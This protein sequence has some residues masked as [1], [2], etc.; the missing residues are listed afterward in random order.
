MKK[1]IIALLLGVTMVSVG[2]EKVLLRLNY[3]KGDTY[4]M[5]M[6]MSQNMGATMSMN[7]NM[8]MLQDVKSVSGDEYEIDSKITKIVMNMSQG[9]MQMSYDSSKKE[10]ELDQTGKMMKAQMGPMLQAVITTKGNNLGKVLET[11]V[12][13]NVPG[14]SDLTQQSSSVIYPENEVSVG[15]TWTMNKDNK[16]MKFNFVYKVKEITLKNVLLDISGTVEGMA[17]GSITGSMNLDKKSGL[18]LTSIINMAM[19]VQGQDLK[20]NVDMTMVKK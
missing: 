10:E 16:G 3:E 18:P 15:D 6:K 12:V 9:G 20:T 11:T 14:A 13:P 4:E 2:Q 17:T 1:I 19:K 8:I 5:N 7:T